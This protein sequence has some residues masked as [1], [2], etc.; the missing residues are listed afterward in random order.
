MLKTRDKVDICVYFLKQRGSLLNKSPTIICFLG[1]TGNSDQRL[2]FAKAFYTYSS[3]NVLLLEYRG[4]GLSRGKPSEKGLYLDAKAA[5][6][7]AFSRDDLDK[8]KINLFGE[9]IGAAVAI[10]AGL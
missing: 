10:N 6:D 4:C 8:S 5:I 1:N 7:Y 3:S 9:N 2:Q